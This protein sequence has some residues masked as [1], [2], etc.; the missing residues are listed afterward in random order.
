MP[1]RTL[2]I[3]DI[4]GCDVALETLLAM[5]APRAADTV[6]LL[7]DLID[8]GPDSRKVVEILLE[9]REGCR[10]ISI[11]GNHEEMLLDALQDPERSPLW[12][13]YGGRETVLSYGGRIEN[14]P[15]EHTEFLASGLPFWETDAAIC[16]HANLEPGV[17]LEQQLAHWLRWQ[18]LTGRERPHPSGK[19]VICGHT[20]QPS[21]LPALLD[22]WVCLDTLAYAGLYLTALDLESGEIYQARQ[23]GQS[24]HGA[25]LEDFA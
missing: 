22:G 2:I 1:G 13:E 12:W 19:R 9:L 16:V 7:G 21:G 11:L 3:G 10:L 14:V 23:T 25:M 5:L 17:P 15:Q 6:V 4:H 18:R 24:R 20:P 8:R